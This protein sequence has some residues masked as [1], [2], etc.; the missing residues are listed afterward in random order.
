MTKYRQ[1]GIVTILLLRKKG[2]KILNKEHWLAYIPKVFAMSY[3]VMNI[4]N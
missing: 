3:Y 2:K 4:I 1:K